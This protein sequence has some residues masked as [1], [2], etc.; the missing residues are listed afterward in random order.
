MDFVKPFR[1][2]FSL[3][4]VLMLAALLSSH[5][6]FAGDLRTQPVEQVSGDQSVKL[7]AY[8]PPIELNERLVQALSTLSASAQR[9]AVSRPLLD[10]LSPIFTATDGQNED[11]K[12]SSVSEWLE[13]ALSPVYQWLRGFRRSDSDKQSLTGGT[14]AKEE[15]NPSS[16]AHLSGLSSTKLNQAVTAAADQYQ[17]VLLSVKRLTIE[18]AIYRIKILRESGELRTLDYSEEQDQ[19]ISEGDESWYANTVD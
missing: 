1:F 4:M 17:G 14:A 16:D 7:A 12:S 18:Q 9:L 2:I 5:S 3:S 8:H 19:F 11:T 15:E 13:T 10:Q 6:V